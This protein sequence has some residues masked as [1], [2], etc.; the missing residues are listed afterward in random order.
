MEIMNY[1]SFPGLG[2]E[3]FHLDK[4]AFTV[5]G[6]GVAWYGV[7]I[8]SAMIVAVLCAVWLAK[9]KEGISV[10]DITD[11]AFIVILCGVAGAR[12]Y[13]VIFTW[14]IYGYLVTDGNFFCKYCGEKFSSAT[15]VRTGYCTKNEKNHRHCLP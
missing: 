1:L 13:Y 15:G 7:L 5:F 10:D 14:N 11:F 2:I 4:I 12:L 8:T 3:P 9:N 6:R